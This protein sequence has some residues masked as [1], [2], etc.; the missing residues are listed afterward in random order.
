MRSMYSP[1]AGSLIL[2]PIRPHAGRT[3][4]LRNGRRDH[5]ARALGWREC[6][7]AVEQITAPSWPAVRPTASTAS[8]LP[9]PILFAARCGATRHT[10]RHSVAV[11]VVEAVGNTV[12]IS[13]RIV[14]IEGQ[15]RF[16]AVGHAITIRIRDP[17]ITAIGG[18][19]AVWTP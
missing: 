12:A 7:T 14:R 9:S 1:E 18:T 4:R 5:A 17:S 11:D 10:V 19:R 2:A 13:V 15:G 16:L 6:P 8:T 3:L